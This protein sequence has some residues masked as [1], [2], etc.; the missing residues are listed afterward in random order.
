MILAAVVFGWPVPASAG[1]T[2]L[3]LR[4]PAG[5]EAGRWRAAEERTRDELRMM[6]LRVEEVRVREDIADVERALAEHG[7][8]A[9]IRVRREGPYGRAEVWWVDPQQGEPR[10]QALEGVVIDGGEAAAVAAL[11]TAELVHA[12]AQGGAAEKA[13]VPADR[14]A[15]AAGGVRVLVGPGGEGRVPAPPGGDVRSDRSAGSGGEAARGAVRSDRSEVGGA[16]PSG[17]VRS[18][19][20]AVGGAASSGAVRSDRRAGSGGAKGPARSDRAA[21]VG[22]GSARVSAAVPDP[23]AE[24]VEP[25]VEPSAE[26]PAAE[27]AE[28]RG[29]F[30]VFAAVGGGP[31]GAGVLVGGGLA[32]QWRWTRG[33]WLRGELH[34]GTGVGW[35]SVDGGEFRLGA[36]GVSVLLLWIGR[37]RA[38]VSPRLGFGGGPALAWA[39]GRAA[40]SQ[41][42]DR[43]WTP[44]GALRGLAG[45][46]IRARPRLRVVAGVEVELLLPPIAVQVQGA[47]VGRL[48]T[49]IVRGVLGLEWGRAGRPR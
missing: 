4:A 27:R 10:V 46:A 11:R 18:D 9:A 38:R 31:G 23:V 47:E 43:D 33:L 16:G 45:A 44:V 34:G 13:A 29:A 20:S 17:D 6:G 28:G 15:R 24:L 12:V 32:A 8:R 1:A 19:R 37:E 40:G 7:A 26:A 30:G 49:P 14:P 5:R 3:L 35:R 25:L 41:A 21:E 48:G 22:G 2:V 36:A 39:L 42:R